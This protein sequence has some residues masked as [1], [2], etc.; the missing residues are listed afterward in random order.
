MVFFVIIH[1]HLFE[2]GR[3]VTRWPLPTIDNMG[4]TYQTDGK[5]VAKTTVYLVGLFNIA[6]NH[7]KAR[8]ILSI[9]LSK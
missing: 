5:C 3:E 7:L 9:T 8:L 2:K 6:L 4:I 1:R